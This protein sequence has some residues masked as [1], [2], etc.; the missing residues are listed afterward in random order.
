[1]LTSSLLEPR[2]NLRMLS[3]RRRRHDLMQ[4]NLARFCCCYLEQ[5]SLSYVGE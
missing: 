3:V 5:K 2:R 1:M 4:K